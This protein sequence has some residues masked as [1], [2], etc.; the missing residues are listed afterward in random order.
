MKKLITLLLLFVSLTAAAQTSANNYIEKY[1]E[2]AVK[3]MNLHG[4]PASIILAVAMHE[5]ANGTSQIA[6]YLNNHF[7]MKGKN[8][9][10]KIRSSYRGYESVESSYEDFIT[11]LKNRRQFNTLFDKY[12]HYDY[13]N[14]VWGIQ[15]GGYAASRTWGSQVMATIKKFKLYEY[16]NRPEAAPEPVFNSP[17]P[18]AKRTASVYKVKKGDTLGAIS[19]K[20][21]V[22]VKSLMRKN[23]LKSTSLD[24]GQRLKI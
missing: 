6:K 21:G 19:K 17:V 16:D 4:V 7:G 20:T 15:R 9:S 18:A 8:S 23:S 5:S 24:I 11:M 3:L 13:K 1:K 12:T 22:P 2:D 14:W 10:T